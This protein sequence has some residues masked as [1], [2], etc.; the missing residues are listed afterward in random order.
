MNLRVRSVTGCS[1]S[2]MFAIYRWV[3]ASE[4]GLIVGVHTT[5]LMLQTTIFLALEGD[6]HWCAEA[7][8]DIALAMLVLPK[9]SRKISPGFSPVTSH[10]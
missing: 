5:C 1:R 9:L 7:R 8:S 3:L 2:A 4:F 10:L 6:V